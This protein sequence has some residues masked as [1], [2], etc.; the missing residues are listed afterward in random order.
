MYKIEFKA[1]VKKDF[2]NIDK[3]NLLF[4][5]DSLKDFANNFSSDYEISLMQ[6]GIIKKLKGQKEDIYRLKLRSYRVVY[7][8]ENDLL[9]I[10]VLSVNTRENSYK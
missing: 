3:S 5:K 6:K 9:I 2:K 7:K 10:L 8:K 4:I 1:S